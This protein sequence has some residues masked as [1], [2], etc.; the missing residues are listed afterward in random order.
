MK[1]FFDNR[2][3]QKQKFD[4]R[5]IKRYFNGAL[6]DF[7]IASK[8]REAEVIFDFSYKV[9]IKLGIVAIAF[10][11]YRVRS[12]ISHHVKILEKLSQ[13]LKDRDI[14]IIGNKMRKKRNLDLYEGGI[15]ISLK[16]AKEYL[17]FIKKVIN[18]I[19]RYLKSQN[20]LF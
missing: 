19:E 17:N 5:T 15:I 11:G 13:I 7:K 6:K 4:S 3:F 9:L 12:R 14:E 16:E 2:F 18:K 1:L 8:N 20:S 10:C